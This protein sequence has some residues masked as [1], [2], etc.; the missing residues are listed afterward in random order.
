[1]SAAF[2]G[3]LLKPLRE[4][5][6]LLHLCGESGKTTFC[7]MAG[8]V[9]GIPDIGAGGVVT[10]W[11]ATA[12]SLEN[13]A[14]RANDGFMVFDEMNTA[15]RG[16]VGKAVYMFN[17][18]AGKARMN[19]DGTERDKR[20]W[21][22]FGLS[23]GEPSLADKMLEDGDTLHAGQERCCISV[24]ADAGKG[25]GVVEDRHGY[26]SPKAFIDGMRVKALQY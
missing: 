11:N 8:S 14:A 5:T 15:A 1:M 24:P 21:R 2:A 20:T 25:A 7:M 26:P 10:S 3:P 12:N 22:F 13:I 18:G 4:D 16:V 6:R 17:S 23:N 9:W 19:A